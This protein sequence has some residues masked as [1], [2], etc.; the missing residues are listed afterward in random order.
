MNQIISVIIC[1]YNREKYIEESIVSILNQSVINYKVELVII[2]NNSTDSTHEICSAL[3]LKYASKN[4]I[5]HIEREQGLSISRNRGIELSNGEILVFID[6]DAIAHPHFLQEIINSYSTDLTMQASGGRIY[7]RFE[8]KEPKWMSPFLLPLM[9]VIDKGNKKRK[10]RGASYPIGANMA[11]RRSII[12]DIGL[13]N[14]N[15]GR[16]GA[17]LLGGEE[18]DF[19]NRMKERKFNVYYLPFACVHHIIPDSRLDPKFLK[20]LG[21]GIG[22]SEKIRALNINK[23]K[24]LISIIQEFVKWFASLIILFY[25]LLTIRSSKGIM[26]IKF[27]IWVTKGLLFNFTH[28]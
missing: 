27:R 1:T 10:F 17:T 5:Y 19:F 20:K 9:S 25:Y 7:P 11:F 6:D 13:F 12:K 4:I 16:T 8:S 21:L 18:K 2:N 26:I 22:S 3:L 24:Y 28:V 15:L 23:I 14:V